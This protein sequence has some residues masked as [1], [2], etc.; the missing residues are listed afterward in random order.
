MSKHTHNTH[1]PEETV[2]ASFRIKD[3]PKDV[4]KRHRFRVKKIDKFSNQMGKLR[5][6]GEQD[7]VNLMKSKGEK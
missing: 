1:E 4:Q 6:E 5:E 2:F 3:L 7:L